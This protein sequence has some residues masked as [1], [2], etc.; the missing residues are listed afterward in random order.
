MLSILANLQRWPRSL[1]HHCDH[2]IPNKRSPRTML[3]PCFQMVHSNGPIINE[4]RD[5]W[6]STPSNWITHNLMG[7]NPKWGEFQL[8]S[9][10]Q[11]L[12]ITI[13]SNLMKLRLIASQFTTSWGE[14]ERSRRILWTEVPIRSQPGALTR[15]GQILFHAPEGAGVVYL[16]WHAW[17]ITFSNW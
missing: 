8:P 15:L 5:S 7:Y 13:W 3:D 4:P 12:L 16:E 11:F 17:R 1:A 6:R 9:K 14:T 2:P 10:S